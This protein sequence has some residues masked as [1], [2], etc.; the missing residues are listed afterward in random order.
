MKKIL[1][2]LIACIASVVIL[3]LTDAPETTT[4]DERPDTGAVLTDVLS[5]EVL[6]EGETSA[7]QTAAYDTVLDTED[8]NTVVHGEAYYTVEDV[9]YYLY[10]YAELPP[11]YMT[12]KEAEK[13][14]WISSEGNLWE[15]ADGAVIGGDRFGNYEG[16]LPKDASYT[17][18]DVN[19]EGGYRNGERLVF[20][21]DG[22][23]Y[24]TS[25]HYASFEQL[26]SEE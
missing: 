11:N 2:I 21:D 10:T 22:N 16:L 18:C 7:P 14:G 17:E 19:Y 24:Y 4:T 15:V 1:L 25:D 13:C 26:Y 12:K 9:A 3:V 5:A 6:P 8:A 23:I 20:D